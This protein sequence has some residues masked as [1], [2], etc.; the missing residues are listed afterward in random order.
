S[1]YFQ[2]F[3]ALDFC[4]SFEGIACY[5]GEH[6]RLMDHWRHVLSIRIHEVCYEDLVAD[7]ERVTRELLAYCGLSWDERC[8]A[9][10]KTSRAVQTASTMQVRKP[11]SMRSVGRWR[12]YQRHLRPLLDALH[13]NGELT[14]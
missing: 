1:C 9:F 12:H 6:E 4:W 3:D 10:H 11:L 2:N 14:E 5:F 13:S 7:Q 8:L